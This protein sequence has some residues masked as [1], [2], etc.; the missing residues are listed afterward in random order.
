LAG[1]FDALPALPWL[2]WLAGLLLWSRG[3]RPAAVV[4]PAPVP[5]RR[6]EA[7]RVLLFAGLLL[8][9]LL[10]GGW[11]R[12]NQLLPPDT[13]ISHY[14]YDDEGVYAG[15]SQLWLQGIWPYRDYFFAHPP[16]AAIAYAPAMG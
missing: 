13:G 15:T 12:L 6:G 8:V 16:L 9:L 3:T 14:P 1:H 4:D 10:L 7:Q 11:A 5:P 2:A